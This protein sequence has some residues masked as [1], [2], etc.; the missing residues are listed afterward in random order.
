MIR[1]V[2]YQDNIGHKLVPEDAAAEFE[3]TWRS[4][5]RNFARCAKSS[6]APSQSPCAAFSLRSKRGRGAPF[7]SPNLFTRDYLY[8]DLWA[9]EGFLFFKIAELRPPSTITLITTNRLGSK[10]SLE[11]YISGPRL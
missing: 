5:V 3:K 6:A 2:G 7:I 8:L 10:C 11:G 9:D 1:L 4:E